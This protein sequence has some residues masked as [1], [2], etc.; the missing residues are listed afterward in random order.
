MRASARTPKLLLADDRESLNP[1]HTIGHST[2]ATAEFVALLRE[3][4]ITLL[5]D[6]RSVPR[7]RT[8]P[9]FNADV[10]PIALRD[11]DIGYR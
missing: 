11:A 3:V 8:N 7:S 9:Q 4:A 5:V 10:L 2:R 1:I 6:V